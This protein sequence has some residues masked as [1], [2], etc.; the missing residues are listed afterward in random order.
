[1]IAAE[2]AAELGADLGFASADDVWDEIER[3]APAFAGV[4]AKDLASIEAHDGILVPR[5]PSRRRAV[6]PIDPIATPGV[7]SVDQQGAAPRVGLVEPPT[8][9]G[10]AH[11]RRP[12]LERTGGEPVASPGPGAGLAEMVD[13]RGD[14]H[15][16]PVDSYSLRLLSARRLYDSGA[17][18]THSPSLVPLVPEATV[19]ANPY[20]LDRL[21]AHGG[22]AVTVRSARGALTLPCEPDERVPRGVVAIDFGLP[23]QQLGTRNA[24]AALIGAGDAVVD[25]RMESVP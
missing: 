5:R 4:T 14:P 24:A 13:A 22:D 25:V 23:A 20:D 19:R 18:V 12:P 11:A 6:L 17:A 7:E 15:V 9:D 3:L 8:A 1:M 21:G 10:G 16:A 2:L